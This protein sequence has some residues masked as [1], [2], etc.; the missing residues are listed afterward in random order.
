M[1]TTQQ[2]PKAYDY[3]KHGDF[4]R[5]YDTKIKRNYWMLGYFS[6]GSIADI[7]ALG[8]KFSEATGIPLDKIYIDEILD[9][10]RFKSCKFISSTVENQK[11]DEQV[12]Q[13]IT[14]DVYAWFRN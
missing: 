8:L 3:T 9:S 2:T 10:R 12:K 5:Y 6:N 1:E 4:R 13:D 7:Y 11:M 14:E